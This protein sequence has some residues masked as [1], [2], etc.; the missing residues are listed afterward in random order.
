MNPTPLPTLR[1]SEAILPKGKNE[2]VWG[3]F[4]GQVV[5]AD[6][7]EPIVGAA[8]VVF[9]MKNVPNLVEGHEAFYDARSAVSD[10]GGR[11][12]IPRR[13]PP[14]FV[15]F[16]ISRGPFLTSDAPGY[17]PYDF[18]PPYIPETEADT[19]HEGAILIRMQARPSVVPVQQRCSLNLDL[20]W[21]RGI[22]LSGS[23][24][25][26]RRE[27]GLPPMRVGCGQVMK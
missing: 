26:K 12:V 23:I 6:T 8:I 1:K 11:F 10:S 20:S 25:A 24:N 15:S 13:P 18:I 3:P 16:V 21:A 7:G 22:D 5:A 19:L 14:A 27:M 17:L 2:N 9:W 4:E